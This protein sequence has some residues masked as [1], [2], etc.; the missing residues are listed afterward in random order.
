MRPRDEIARRDGVRLARD[1]HAGPRRQRRRRDPRAAPA[2]SAT[3]AD[4]IVIANTKGF[5][6]HPM[7]V[8]IEDVVAVKALETGIVPPVPELPGARPGAGRAQPLARAAP[9]RSATRCGWPPGSARRSACCCCAGRRSPTAAAATPTSSATTTG[10]PTATAW[11][12]LAAPASAATTSRSSRS[13]STGCASS[14]RARRR[15]GRPPPAAAGARR[16]E[17]RRSSRGARRAAAG[18]RGAEPRRAEPR[19]PSRLRRPR[20]SRDDDVAARVLAIVAEQTGYPPDLLD[21]DLDLE[22]DLGIDTVKQAEVFAAIRETLRDRARR[23]AEAARLPDAQ[24]R[25]RLR[26]R[27]ARAGR[28]GAGRADAA[29]PRPSPRR[30][31]PAPAGR[32]AAR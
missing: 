27:R 29:P 8:G 20:R 17:P 5:T 12:A 9:T 3:D 21:L 22:A 23:H 11:K 32:A 26:R 4:Q 31:R 15:R 6:G 28:A 14:T 30:R 25:R 19:R 7:G 2:S 24:P 13:S 1:L 10:S 18:R 16:V